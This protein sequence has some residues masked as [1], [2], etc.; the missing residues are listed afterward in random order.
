MRDLRSGLAQGRPS[1]CRSAGSPSQSAYV[2]ELCSVTEDHAADCRARMCR[3][4][5][6]CDQLFAVGV[7]PE[8]ACAYLAAK[9]RVGFDIRDSRMTQVK[10]V[11]H[12]WAQ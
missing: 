10:R 1:N 9:L 7:V 2:V 8:S 5:I 4:I 3:C 12:E 6:G 11:N